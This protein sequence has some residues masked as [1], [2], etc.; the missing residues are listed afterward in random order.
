[1]MIETLLSGTLKYAC[2]YVITSVFFAVNSAICWNKCVTLH[3][4]NAMFWKCRIFWI[5][6]YVTSNHRS[7]TTVIC[8]A[9]YFLQWANGDA[10]YGSQGVERDAHE[11]TEPDYLMGKS[12]KFHRALD[13]DFKV[14]LSFL[15]L[16]FFLL[17]SKT[18]K[19]LSR[20]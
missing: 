16:L 12:C 17:F 20:Y 15:Y 19:C 13:I 14:Q 4:C 18:S 7:K 2:P 5:I 6:W 10:R 11:W 9:E 1:M 3:S 8:R